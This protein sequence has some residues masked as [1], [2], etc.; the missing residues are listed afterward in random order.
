MELQIRELKDEQN[1]YVLTN[2]DGILIPYQKNTTLDPFRLSESGHAMV[3]VEF[4]V[5][6]GFVEF[7]GEVND[8]DEDDVET[9]DSSVVQLRF[10]E[11][12]SGICYFALTD[13]NGRVVGFQQSTVFIS[14]PHSFGVLR[15]E[16]YLQFSGSI[17][18]YGRNR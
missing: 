5:G 11:E 8:S 7:S 15:V 4:E 1:L 6:K 13:T 9:P 2:G 12:S 3:T 17:S 10:K 14:Q 16:F 18:R